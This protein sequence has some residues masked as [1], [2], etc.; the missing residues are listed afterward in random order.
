MCGTAA[1]ISPMRCRSDLNVVLSAGYSYTDVSRDFTSRTLEFRDGGRQLANETILPFDILADP[2]SPL[3]RID[4][5]QRNLSQRNDDRYAEHPVSRRSHR[6]WRLCQGRGRVDRRRP[7]GSGRTLRI[8]RS[9]DHHWSIISAPTRAAISSRPLNNDYFLP[10]ATLTWNFAD[11]FQFRVNGSKTVARPQFRE[12]APIPF[13]DVE[14]DRSFS[15]NP[16]LVDSELIN[17][18]ARVE[19]YPGR[20]ER[21]SIAGFYKNIDNPIETIARRER[22]PPERHIRQCA[23]RGPLWRRDRTGEILSA[24]RLVLQR[25]LC[26]QAD[27]AFRRTTPTASRA[28]RPT[29]TTWCAFT[30]RRTTSSN[31]PPIRCSSMAARLPGSPNIS[32]ICNSVSKIPNSCS[33]SRFCL[34]MPATASPIAVPRNTGGGIDPD[35]VESPGLRLDIVAREGFDI[36]G[37]EFE[38]KFEARNI[39]GTRL[40]RATIWRRLYRAEQCL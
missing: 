39:T 38:L 13:Q 27:R 4:R 8:W 23:E 11:D 33:K 29:R 15:G 25:P 35:I 10:A 1:S 20:G 5:F 14:S 19:Y 26:H 12:L 34:A 18:E 16:F 36:S 37:Q 40:L 17:A 3:P 31:C 6:A 7:P 22:K 21:I 24:R 32:P 28:S 30:A 9:I 2:V